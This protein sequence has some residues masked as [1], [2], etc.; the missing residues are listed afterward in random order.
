MIAVHFT[1][2]FLGRPQ[3]RGPLIVLRLLMTLFTLA[4][5][6]FPRVTGMLGLFL[7]GGAK[8]LPQNVQRVSVVALGLMWFEGSMSG[9]HVLSV[10]WQRTHKRVDGASGEIMSG[11]WGN[12]VK[13]W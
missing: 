11:G 10:K 3:G 8:T 6:L 9:A 4:E 12:Q 7:G 2:G 5:R 13:G 1:L